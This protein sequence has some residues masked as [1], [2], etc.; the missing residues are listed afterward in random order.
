MEATPQDSKINVKKVKSDGT[1][2]YSPKKTYFLS[3]RKK[4]FPHVERETED[5][6]SNSSRILCGHLH[7]NTSAIGMNPSPL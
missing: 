7:I 4:K 1:K 6:S 3:I 5:P 2:R